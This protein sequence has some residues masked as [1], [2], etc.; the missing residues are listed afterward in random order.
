M[1]ERENELQEDLT[2]LE[3]LKRRLRGDKP[4][5]L[6]EQSVVTVSETSQ[7]SSQRPIFFFLAAIFILL[8]QFI[9]ESFKETFRTPAIVFYLIGGLAFVLAKRKGEL[10]G[11]SFWKENGVPVKE[12]DESEITFCWYWLVLAI[13]FSLGGVILLKNQDLIWLV[14]LLWGLSV[15]FGL[16]S[17]WEFGSKR[18]R[19]SFR[20]YV[21]K[22]LADKVW[23]LA[24]LVTF[25]SVLF[26]QF[27]KIAEIPKEMISTQVESFLSTFGILKGDLGLWFPRNL[28]SE[29]LTYY[30]GALFGLIT[31]SQFGYTVFKASFAIAGLVSA[32]FTYKLVRLLFDRETGLIATFLLG[33]GY[34]ALI[35]QRAVVG[36]GLVLPVLAPALYHFFKSLFEDDNNAHL[37][38]ILFAC[39][40]ILTNK[41]FLILPVLNLIITLLFFRSNS[42]QNSSNL[43]IMRIGKG[44]MLGL[45]ILLPFLIVVISNFQ[46][47]ISPISN[48][49][50]IA[51]NSG[52]PL[53]MFLKN[54]LS[55]SGI[56]FWNN[57]SS[58]VDGIPFRPVFDWVSAGFFLFGLLSMLFSTKEGERKKQLAY[59]ILWIGFLIYP[60]LNLAFPNENPAIGKHLPILFLSLVLA[61]RGMSLLWSKFMDLQLKNGY[62]VK[63]LL[64]VVLILIISFSN[65]NLL[66]EGYAKQFDAS[67]WNASEMAHVIEVYDQGI[68]SKTNSFIVG[69]PHWVDARAVAIL[70]GAPDEELALMPEEIKNTTN[71]TGTKIFLLNPFDKESIAKLQSTY[72]QGIASTF[73]SLNPDKN[74]VIYIVGQ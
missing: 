48:N 28:V 14:F 12:N 44:L 17:F 74:F 26:F 55:G 64:A 45:I 25:A 21:E 49:L 3:Y 4:V 33:V 5:I 39:L 11:L 23:L 66:T 9:L 62:A 47:W 72:P 32:L 18:E 10:D 16:L 29:P 15:I 59:L 71:T 57:R 73:Q 63:I 1:D 52:N 70:L 61:S 41:V 6:G 56:A 50:Y 22:A 19:P 8:G 60:S 30:W 24:V 34:W 53:I 51:E 67:A 38:S 7:I 40:G 27:V 68:E 31:G 69:Y 13:I 37:L 42:K 65:Y 43:M 35:Q 54:M 58:W 46:A 2:L 20:Q 36:Y